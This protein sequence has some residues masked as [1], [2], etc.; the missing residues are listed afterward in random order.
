MT[1]SRLRS[2][3]SR[4]AETAEERGV[5]DVTSLR[6]LLVEILDEEMHEMEVLV[7]EQV[8]GGYDYDELSDRIAGDKSDGFRHLRVL[9]Q[10]PI[11]DEQ[12]ARHA[13]RRVRPGRQGVKREV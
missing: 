2:V 3:R 4:L 9:L 11:S 1:S 12:H 6:A 10:R 5:E 8:L 13:R 7:S